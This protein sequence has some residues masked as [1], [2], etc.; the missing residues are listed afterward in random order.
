MR[1]WV[2]IILFIVL[3]VGVANKQSSIAKFG[4]FDGE[5]EVYSD[6]FSPNWDCSSSNKTQA[7]AATHI[8]TQQFCTGDIII[9]RI[10]RGL[11]H[12]T[13]DGIEIY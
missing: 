13:Q 10:D 8:M 7:V 9:N 4:E 3:M 1:F 6:D 2:I 12:Y 5:A 11:W